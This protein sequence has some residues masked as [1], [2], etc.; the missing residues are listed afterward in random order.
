MFFNAF[1]ILNN[2]KVPTMHFCLTARP[3]YLLY[4]SHL[5][6]YY[7]IE[8]ALNILAPDGV[9]SFTIFQIQKDIR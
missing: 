2:A 6:F 1:P 3:L 7:R 9:H 5:E 8:G 4:L